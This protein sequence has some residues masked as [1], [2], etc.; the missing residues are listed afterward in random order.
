M[1]IIPKKINQL[2]IATLLLLFVAAMLL[3]FAFMDFMMAT[4]SDGSMSS[5]PFRMNGSLCN[6]DFQEHLTLTKLAFT[7]LPQKVNLVYIVY[8]A[9]A[10]I[11]T[12]SISQHWVQAYIKFLYLR[13]LRYAKSTAVSIVIPIQEAFSRG[14]INPKIF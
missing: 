10:F 11:I 9:A 2:F 5:C 14:I 4:N 6:M 3:S 8:L 13:Q 7:A 12:L 1:M